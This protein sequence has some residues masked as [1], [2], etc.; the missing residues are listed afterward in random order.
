MSQTTIEDLLSRVDSKY[1]LV[2]LAA[3]RAQQ[4]NRGTPPA[5]TP[6]NHKPTYI[7]LEEIAAGR[8]TYEVEP[9][10]VTA[11]PELPEGHKP[12]WFRSLTPEEV[13]P[14]GTVLEEEE[15]AA[16]PEAEEEGVEEEP[17]EALPE[18]ALEEEEGEEKLEGFQ[19]VTET[20]GGEE[21]EA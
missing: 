14:E 2:V 16:T 19:E 5:L 21:G 20:E 7:A 18:G 8:V 1:R 9:V 15:V 10:E 3:R 6:K 12:T 13:I 11:A 17:A 4:L